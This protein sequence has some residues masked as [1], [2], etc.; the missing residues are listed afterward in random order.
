MFSHDI[1]ELCCCYIDLRLLVVDYNLFE[2]DRF[3]YVVELVGFIS[4]FVELFRYLLTYGRIAFMC[5]ESFYFIYL[6]LLSYNY[7]DYFWRGFWRYYFDK[8]RGC[9]CRS[10]LY[11]LEGLNFI[12]FNEPI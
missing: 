9:Y 1:I 3:I 11:I 5:F 8:I 2:R 4:R 10:I 6:D 12:K 7:R